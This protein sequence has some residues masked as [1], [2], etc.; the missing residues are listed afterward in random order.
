MNCGLS[1]RCP[2]VI[3]MASGWRPCSQARWVLVLRQPRERPTRRLLLPLAAAAGTG[4]VLVGPADGRVDAH[5]P[6]NA[7]GSG[8]VGLQRGQD[9]RPTAVALPAP[10]PDPIDD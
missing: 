9:H 8:G 1:P 5:R 6:V 7:P 3:T 4:R 10:Q 2:P